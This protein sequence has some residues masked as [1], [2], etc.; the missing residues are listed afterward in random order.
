MAALSNAAILH[1]PAL[2]EDFSEVR[3][4]LAVPTV[5]A[6]ESVS[7][8]VVIMRHDSPQHVAATE[9]LDFAD[10]KER[11]T[12]YTSSHYSAPASDDDEEDELASETQ[13]ASVHDYL[14]G[15]HNTSIQR[16]E[17][18]PDPDGTTVGH[19]KDGNDDERSGVEMDYSDSDFEEDIEK[20]LLEL[21]EPSIGDD[22]SVT[23]LR[24]EGNSGSSQFPELELSDEEEEDHLHNDTIYGDKYPLEAHLHHSG[25]EDSEEEEEEDEYK[26]L[27]PPQELDPEKLYALYEFSGPDTSHCQL[28]QDESCVLLNDE[29]S[30]WWLVKRCRDNNIGFAPAEILETFPERLARLNCWKNENIVSEATHSSQSLDDINKLEREQQEE[31]LK[32]IRE[33]PLPAGPYQSKNKSVSFNDIVSYANR[34]IEDDD[35]NTINSDD[36]NGQDEQAQQGGAPNHYDE[37]TKEPIHFGDEEKDLDEV[38]DVSFATGYSQPL[39]VAKIRESKSIKNIHDAIEAAESSKTPDSD[40]FAPVIMIGSEQEQPK[41][42]NVNDTNTSTDDIQKVFEAPISPFTNSKQRGLGV[43]DFPSNNSVPTIGEYSPSSSEFNDS[44]VLQECTFTGSTPADEKDHIDPESGSDDEAA[45]TFIPSTKAVQDISKLVH[46]GDTSNVT[47]EADDEDTRRGTSQSQNVEQ[48]D[49]TPGS[50]KSDQTFHSNNGDNMSVNSKYSS[51]S[52]EGFKMESGVHHLQASTTSITSNN[53]ASK[54]ATLEFDGN[55]ATSGHEESRTTCDPDTLN[56]I[57]PVVSKDRHPFID[58]L[59]G[60]ILTKIDSLMAKIDQLVA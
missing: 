37:F 18:M 3:D 57:T 60:P 48:V 41:E 43:S 23:I 2:V 29:D 32:L 35:S 8:S 11:I 10:A 30:Y 40:T 28:E 22:G 12:S 9:P 25:E 20:R 49:Q 36:D 42:T 26:P 46:S 47:I 7:G 45:K 19:E 17:V 27:P 16:S 56:D 33:R 55:L 15:L 59:Y 5:N 50:P 21:D 44:P 34:F 54:T 53:S 38:S 1:D 24:E 13:N 51:T 31:I 58:E 4:T 52:D 6:D 39:N 14:S